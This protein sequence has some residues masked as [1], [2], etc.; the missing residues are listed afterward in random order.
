[1][2]VDWK[3]YVLPDRA[4]PTAGSGLHAFLL[5]SQTSPVRLSAA[6]LRR[7]DTRLVQYLIAVGRDW[8]NRGLPFTLSDVSPPL[9]AILTQIGATQSLLPTQEPGA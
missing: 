7:I 6:T 8:A 3:T 2:S 1:M 4:E 9:A 5:A